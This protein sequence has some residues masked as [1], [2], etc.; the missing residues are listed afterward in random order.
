MEKEKQGQL[1]KSVEEKLLKRMEYFIDIFEDEKNEKE[2]NI[3]TEIYQ[4]MIQKK[5]K[6]LQEKKRY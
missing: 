3:K 5:Q 2:E 1:I 6:S 4:E